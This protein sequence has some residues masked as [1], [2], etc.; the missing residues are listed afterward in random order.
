MAGRPRGAGAHAMSFRAESTTIP[1]SRVVEPSAGPTVAPGT[2]VSGRS[3]TVAGRCDKLHVVEAAVGA[4]AERGDVTGPEVSVR[5][6]S[7]RVGRRVARCP[8]SGD[9]HRRSS[10]CCKAVNRLTRS[11]VLPGENDVSAGSPPRGSSYRSSRTAS[12]RS[13]SSTTR[14]SEA[15]D[16]ISGQVAVAAAY[17]G[18]HRSARRHPSWPTRDGGRPRRG[19]TYPPSRPAPGCRR[20]R[21]GDPPAAFPQAPG[22]T[23]GPHPPAARRGELIDL[24]LAATWRDASCVAQER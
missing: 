7:A 16:V 23:V 18:G 4:R 10:S 14:R 19:T 8:G 13:R 2:S 3:W 15:L 21:P 20:P 11:C 22:R 12:G 5:I 6:T 9:A 24:Q 1:A 17:R